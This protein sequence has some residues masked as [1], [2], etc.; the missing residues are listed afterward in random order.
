MH[1]AK[2][3]VGLFV[4]DSCVRVRVLVVYV[5]FASEPN[6][7]GGNCTQIVRTASHKRDDCD[8]ADYNHYDSHSDRIGPD[9]IGESRLSARLAIEFASSESVIATKSPKSQSRRLR[10]RSDRCAPGALLSLFRFG[11]GFGSARFRRALAR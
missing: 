5:Y 3:F 11:F 10:L 2:L 7:P 8:A 9:R 1:L 4:V 6:A